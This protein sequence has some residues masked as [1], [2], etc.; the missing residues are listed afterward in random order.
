M[1]TFKQ[2]LNEGGNV[3]IGDTS[4][5]RIDLKK[6]PRETAISSFKNGLNAINDAFQKMHGIPLW[7]EHL[8]KSI[9]FLSG[10]TKTFFD[11]SVP[12]DEFV[13]NKSSLGDLDI[14]VD[15]AMADLIQIFLDKSKNKNFGPLKLVGYKKSGEQFITIFRSDLGIN[16]QVDLE[17]V[18][19]SNGRPT[20]WSSFS[21]SSSWDDMK[22]GIKGVFAKYGH[23]SLASRSAQPIILLKGAKQTPTKIDASF[24]TASLKGIRQRLQP[25]LDETDKQKMIDGLPVFTEIPSK[26]AKF[27]N[28]LEV[29]FSMLFD[30]RKATN[31]DIADLESFTGIIKLVNKYV[32]DSNEKLKF[33]DRFAELLWGRGAQGLYRG[34]RLMDF[35]EKS[36]A[37][38]MLCSGL[39]LSTR[40]FL[41]MIRTYYKSYKK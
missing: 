41:P 10:S 38:R 7:D 24:Y 22:S 8:I 9:D 28:D 11:L 21:H 30:G 25:V 40:P 14:M 15:G 19:F 4:A 29:F 3:I 33:V 6:F 26:G 12:T 18:E 39:G 1:K 2:Y 34:N 17:L 27:Y 36:V 37:F 20:K 32:I 13:S 16:I 31:T 23:R 5:E 35:R